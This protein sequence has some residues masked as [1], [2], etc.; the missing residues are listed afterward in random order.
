VKRTRLAPLLAI[1]V[2]AGC[3]GTRTVA[4]D[5]TPTPADKLP[6]STS[7]EVLDHP[8]GLAPSAEEIPGLSEAQ[9][10]AVAEE[11]QRAVNEQTYDTSGVLKGAAAQPARLRCYTPQ[12]GGPRSYAVIGLGVV[13]V[14]V[15][16]NVVGLG[17][18][19]GLCNFFRNVKASPTWTVDNEANSAENVPLGR[20]PWTQVFYNRVACSIEFIGSTGR[21]NEGPAQWTDVQL[22]EGARL[23]AGCFKRAGIPVRRGKVSTR[24]GVIVTGV[25]THQELGRPGGGHTDPGP[26]FNMDRF[27]AYVR[28]FAQDATCDRGCQVNKSYQERHKATHRRL[29]RLGCWT[30][31]GQADHRVS[32]AR[33]LRRNRTLH[34]RLKRR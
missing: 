18:V 21:P 10:D 15:S 25:V 24:G 13:H 20:V 5:P 11:N 23:M 26:F 29:K 16:R 12:N 14:T 4:I 1:L 34:R 3:G 30:A 22:R 32:C 27:I 19:R 2:L 9:E 28:E 7:L 17:D 8:A 31:K 33:M 6:V